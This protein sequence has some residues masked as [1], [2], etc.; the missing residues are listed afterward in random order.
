MTPKFKSNPARTVLTISMGFLVMYL[1]AK[2]DWALKVSVVVGLIGVIST[3]LSQKIE[4][5]WMKLAWVLSLIVPKILLSVIFFLFL[6]PMALIAN[7]FRKSD[8]LMLK[9][10]VDSTFKETNKVF[11][12]SSF[13]KPW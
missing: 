12:K 6:F 13:E 8:P 11:E 1:L 5:A 10:N 9:N 2:W 3:Y 4:W 7:F